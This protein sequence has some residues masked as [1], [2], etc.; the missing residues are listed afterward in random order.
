M[1]S[2]TANIASPIVGALLRYGF[3]SYGIA[4]IEWF[5]NPRNALAIFPSLTGAK[6]LETPWIVALWILPLVWLIVV[7]IGIK[8]T[9]WWGIVLLLP[10]W[11]GM[12]WYII[13]GIIVVSCA[14]GHDCI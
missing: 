9:G 10:I 4:A 11:W 14:T 3:F 5:L 1:I 6:A 13:W 8:K 12:Y 2:R 7:I